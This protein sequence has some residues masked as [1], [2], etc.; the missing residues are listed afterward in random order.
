MLPM[1][2][3]VQRFPKP[4]RRN[5]QSIRRATRVIKIAAPDIWL[6]AIFLYPGV[7]FRSLVD[8]I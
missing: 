7:T 5:T 8:P 2:T 6:L 1:L 3:I 4:P